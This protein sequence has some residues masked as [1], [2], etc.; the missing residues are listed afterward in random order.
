VERRSPPKAF[1]LLG[2][3]VAMGTVASAEAAP[4]VSGLTPP[5]E[6]FGGNAS[7]I[8]S[9]FIPG[10]RCRASHFVR[11]SGGQSATSRWAPTRSRMVA[12]HMSGCSSTML[13]R[14]L[15]PTRRSVFCHEHRSEPLDRQRSFGWRLDPSQSSLRAPFDP[16]CQAFLSAKCSGPTRSIRFSFSAFLGTAKQERGI[17]SSHFATYR[18]CGVVAQLLPTRFRC[19]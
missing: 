10:L 15:R 1:A 8:I 2:F 6:V 18:S 19:V 3:A 12:S 11:A 4:T 17:G 14:S 5:S 7:P 13:D 16:R 9:R